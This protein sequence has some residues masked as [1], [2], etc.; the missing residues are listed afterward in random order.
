MR[1]CLV[2]SYRDA[3]AATSGP[4]PRTLCFHGVAGSRGSE[5][6]R[7][8]VEQGLADAI[9]GQCPSSE[10]MLKREQILINHGNNTRLVHLSHAAHMLLWL[11]FAHV[12]VFSGLCWTRGSESR[13]PQASLRWASTI[14]KPAAGSRVLLPFWDDGLGR[15]GRRLQAQVV[16]FADLG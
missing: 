9:L 10:N 8:N 16:A 3:V 6:A 2:K 7:L 14:A 11:M 12:D 1:W 5:V 15:P 4:A 13:R